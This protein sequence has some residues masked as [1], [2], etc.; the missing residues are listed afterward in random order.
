[1]FRLLMANR[2]GDHFAEHG[3]V[4]IAESSDRETSLAGCV[5]AEFGEQFGV[6][7]EFAEF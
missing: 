2:C 7:L 3:Q 5:F 4:D 6:A 1:M